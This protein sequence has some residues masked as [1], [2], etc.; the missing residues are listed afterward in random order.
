MCAAK[1][2]KKQ[3]RRAS[4]ET[5][6]E[7]AVVV[8]FYFLT[9]FVEFK[10]TET[11]VTLGNPLVSDL[12]ASSWASTRFCIR[13][14]LRAILRAAVGVKLKRVLI[15]GWGRHPHQSER[16]LGLGVF[17][18]RKAQEGQRRRARG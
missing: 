4:N 10:V 14:R 1:C 16:G 2:A 9:T 7:A 11:S 18:G 13:L 15:E 5:Q 6:K 17:A 12:K 8:R 3:C